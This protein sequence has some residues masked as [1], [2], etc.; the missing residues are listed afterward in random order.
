MRRSENAFSS[1]SLSAARLRS[2]IPVSALPMILQSMMSLSDQAT[3]FAWAS[4]QMNPAT[5]PDS[6]LVGTCSSDRHPGS[7]PSTQRATGLSA[8]HAASEATHAI[9]PENSARSI[10]TSVPA[11]TF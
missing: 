10:Q 11:R 8:G 1:R 5:S 9:S 3:S 6:P 4:T 7:A 2:V